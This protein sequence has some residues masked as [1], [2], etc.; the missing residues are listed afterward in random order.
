MCTDLL[1]IVV[2]YYFIGT[3]FTNKFPL[4][5]KDAIDIS[6]FLVL[7]HVLEMETIKQE[8]SCLEKAILTCLHIHVYCAIMEV[9]QRVI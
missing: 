6:I 7:K 3:A 2:K 5:V 9:V 1:K 8:S 4:L